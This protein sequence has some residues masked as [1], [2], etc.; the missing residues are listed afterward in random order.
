MIFFSFEQVWD[1]WK[2]KRSGGRSEKIRRAEQ[3]VV[4]EYVD[5]FFY[6][7]PS[8]KRRKYERDRSGN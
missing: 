6:D 1:S 2:S 3:R 5:I 8:C 4:C 7:L